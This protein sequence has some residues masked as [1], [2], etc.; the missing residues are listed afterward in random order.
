MGDNDDV[1]HGK[2]SRAVILIRAAGARLEA[3]QNV[4]F[5]DSVGA[6]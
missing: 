6:G 2:A 1:L 3:H 5:A 4:G